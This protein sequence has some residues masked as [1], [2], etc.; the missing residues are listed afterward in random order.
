MASLAASAAKNGHLPQYRYFVPEFR[1][2]GTEWTVAG[3]S[4]SLERTGFWIPQL[5][6][7]FDAGVDLPTGSG[8]RPLVVFVTHG[9]IDHC[10]AL[11]MLLRHREHGVDA[12]TQVF[13]PAPIVHRLRSFCQ[14]SWAVKCDIDKDLPEHYGPPPEAEAN[15]EPGALL[16]A[17]S[18]QWRACAAGAAY[19]V[20]LG[21]K[22]KEAYEVHT[23]RLYHKMTTSVGYLLA[24][25]AHTVQR[26]RPDLLGADKRATGANVK[27]ARARGEEINVDVAV[28]E[29]LHFAFVL[30]TTIAAFEAASAT[31]A[32]ILACPVIMTECTF[33]EDAMKDEAAK[34]GH[35]A[36]GELAPYVARA[37]RAREGGA[38]PQTW[39]LVHFS[40]RYSDGDIDAF[41]HD[42]EASGLTLEQEPA[43]GDVAGARR[44]PD[45]VLW[46]DAGPQP[47]WV[48]GV[49]C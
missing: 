49:Q 47:L 13:A 23:L 12:P 31:A 5:R 43:D 14:L 26:L 42:A 29:A 33:L 8:A 15:P 10:N 37:V 7:M 3:H 34:R 20:A 28:P 27:A 24:K 1:I 39:I 32:K 48:S 44:A 38:A 4:R 30:D 22:G 9:H 45:V 17:G 35:T 25:P 46:L 11:P 19:P 2:P 6:C 36:W 40:L 21:K 16:D 18:T 41:F